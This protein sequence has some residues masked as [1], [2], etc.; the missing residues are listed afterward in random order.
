MLDR[1]FRAG[2]L[3]L[4]GSMCL[5]TQ[6]GC[7]ALNIPSQRFHDNHDRGGPLGH[8]KGDHTLRL[9][10]IVGSAIS[11]RR[12]KVT[13]P[14]HNDSGHHDPGHQNLGLQSPGHHASCLCMQCGDHDEFSDPSVAGPSA[15]KLPDVPWP[16]FHPVPTRPVFGAPPAE[17]VW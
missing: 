13:D 1:R 9:D 11:G 17:P 15:G 4:V 2:M 14:G 7:V 5:L 8:L 10:G 16:R 3:L 12:G 6:G